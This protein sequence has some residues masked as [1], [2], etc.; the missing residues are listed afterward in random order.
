M[1]VGT[2]G[3][4]RGGSKRV[5]RG[6]DLRLHIRHQRP[7]AARAG[8]YGRFRRRH[9][10]QGRPDRPVAGPGVLYPG[11]EEAAF[12]GG[13]VVR[14]GAGHREL[15]AVLRLARPAD[16]PHPAGPDRRGVGAAG[17]GDRRP[18]G[19]SR[20]GRLRAA[21][22]LR[23]RADQPAVQRTAK[24]DR[25]PGGFRGLFTDVRHLHGRKSRR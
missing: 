22:S 10:P 17:T 21:D 12:A 6:R 14:G 9:S 25:G 18:G 2:P 20:P 4:G 19:L 16:R 3:A 13:Q 8:R 1:A 7:E 15:Q 24:A 23:R 11:P 5:A